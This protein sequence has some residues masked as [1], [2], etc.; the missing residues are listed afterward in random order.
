MLEIIGNDCA[1]IYIDFNIGP[2]VYQLY[3]LGAETV[4]Y[5]GEMDAKS[6]DVS[7]R[8]WKSGD[9][10]I[11]VATTAFGMGIDKE[12][13]RHVVCYGVPENLCGWAQELG[14]AGRDG[15]LSTVTIVYSSSNINHASAWIKQHHGNREYCKRVL[16]QFG[17]SWKFVLSHV[18]GTC[19]RATLLSLFNQ[20]PQS[21]PLLQNGLCCD[22]CISNLEKLNDQTTDI[23]EDLLTLLNTIKFL[24]VKG[25]LKIA[26]W[27]RGSNAAWTELHDKASSTSYGSFNGHSETWRRGFIKLCNCL[28]YVERELQSLIKKMAVML[29]KPFTILFQ[30]G[31]ID[32]Y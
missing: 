13:I 2:I 29:F 24:G 4:A 20:E 3:N 6:R 19:R 16:K 9:I 12:D 32:L 11:M 26:Q 5:H 7:Y 22:V 17:E 30:R 28:G 15:K 21:T 14:C 25:E 23:T 27:I 8:R 1:V 10:K 18:S 31:G